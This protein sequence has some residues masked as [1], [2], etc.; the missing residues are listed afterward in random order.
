MKYM[1]RIFSMIL[2]ITLLCTTNAYADDFVSA[3]EDDNLILAYYSAVETKESTKFSEILSD[4]YRDEM[5]S[6]LNNNECA[7]M[8][9]GLHNV[10]AVD[11]MTI[12]G[13]IPKDL[14]E[15]YAP[16][17]SDINAADI[18]IYLVS[19][20][21]N[22]DHED[23]FNHNGTNY[24]IVFCGTEHNQRNV[25]DCRIASDIVLNRCLPDDE[26]EALSTQDSC[27]YNVP[28]N[29]IKVLRWN[30]GDG[31]I[32]DVPLK[33][34]VKVTT[35]WEF[36]GDG[37]NENYHYA[38][39][40]A[41]RNYGW[42]FILNPDPNRGYHVTDSGNTNNKQ[43]PSFQHYNPDKYWDPNTWKNIFARTDAI[44]NQNFVSSDYKIFHSWYTKSM[45]HYE[46]C[47]RLDQTAAIDFANN[48]GWTW[49]EI[50]SYFYS[51]SSRSS[52]NI[53]FVPTGTHLYY[54]TQTFGGNKF[55]VCYCGA[56]LF[57]GAAT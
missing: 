39:I 31:T 16:I 4:Q 43:Y 21:L 14:Y 11:E 6:I 47:G 50:L 46:G 33:K 22:V 52:G 48:K 45:A 41:V 36:G 19:C 20:D 56:K 40:L 27:S 44:W 26:L 9:I 30:Y 57:A 42:Y 7:E 2:C 28:P 10:I 12:V 49:Q 35:A 5:E 37:Y 15:Y 25:V 13:E 34:Y 38:G 51:N 23:E 55:R 8:K 17:L 1:K 18:K 54:K 29:T 53:Q 32:E 24:Q 3:T